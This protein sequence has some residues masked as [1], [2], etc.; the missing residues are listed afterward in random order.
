MTGSAL[1]VVF[2]P[3]VA[4]ITLGIWLGMIFYA[5][6]HPEHQAR[7]AAPGAT[8]AEAA[9]LGADADGQAV[10]PK[11]AS[12]AVTGIPAFN[13]DAATAGD[14]DGTGRAP[15]PPGRRAAGAR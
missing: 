3:I 12:W 13:Q 14:R 9:A 11:A 6:A 2:T 1:V 15:V 7:S 4:L 8:G 5:D 10:R